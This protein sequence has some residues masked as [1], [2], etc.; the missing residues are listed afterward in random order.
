LRFVTRENLDKICINKSHE[1]VCLK[2]QGRLHLEL[3]KF[4]EF[5]K[6]LKKSEGNI[7]VLTQNINDT[8]TLGNIIKT[9]IYLGADH[10]IVTKEDKH[11][12]NGGLA[13]ASSGATETTEIFSLK[14]TKNFLIGKNQSFLKIIQI[15]I[16][17]KI[18]FH[19]IIN[20]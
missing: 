14:F 15:S 6:Y 3:K 1:G 18:K 7:V 16:Y 4:Q 19:S 10:F 11:P 8:Y 12:I 13:K 5:Q 2:T 9:G 17:L 20:V